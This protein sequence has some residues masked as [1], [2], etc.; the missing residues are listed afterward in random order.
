MHAVVLVHAKNMAA[1]QNK[2]CFLCECGVDTGQM[3]TKRKKMTGCRA[4]KALE[5]M[6]DLFA[7]NYGR[8]IEMPV[9]KESTKDRY[10]CHK[11]VNRLEK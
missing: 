4:A 5:A 8:P 9:H 7:A 10:I 3:K 11:C 2:I 6:N 1:K